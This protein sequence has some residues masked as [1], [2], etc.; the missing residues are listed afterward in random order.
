MLP[1]VR[2]KYLQGLEAAH[3]DLRHPREV[4]LTTDGAALIVAS[5]R[6]GRPL[7][8]FPQPSVARLDVASSTGLV[9][10][11]TRRAAGVESGEQ[12]LILDV[13]PSPGIPA[14]I[15]EQHIV[16]ASPDEKGVAPRLKFVQDLLVPRTPA[17][18]ARLERGERR[19]HFYF[20][21][22]FLALV[23]LVVALIVALFVLVAA[24]RQQQGTAA[25][26]PAALI[27]GI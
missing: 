2:L 17:Q 7:I 23:L 12:V 3:D 25:P 13:Q 14:A 15:A 10:A 1:R 8:K 22:G 16:F 26:S 5:A 18:M 21:A 19:M 4:D 27:V 24:P 6:S 9:A 20:A 11:E